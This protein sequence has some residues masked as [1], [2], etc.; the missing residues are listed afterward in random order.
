[1][2][3]DSGIIHPLPPLSEVGYLPGKKEFLKPSRFSLLTCKKDH[4][5]SEVNKKLTLEKNKLAK[6]KQAETSFFGK[7]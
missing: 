2:N 7:A 4:E 5:T 3:L 1:M 6:R